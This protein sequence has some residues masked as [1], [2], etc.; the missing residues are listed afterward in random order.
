MIA[1]SE[2]KAWILP[3]IFV[4]SGVVGSLFVL[5]LVLP[6]GVASGVP[7][8]FAV[9]LTKDMPGRR[10][11]VLVGVLCSGLTVAGYFL[12]PPGGKEWQVLV[13]RGLSILAIG[14]TSLFMI[15]WKEYAEEVR[16]RAEDI[17][18]VIDLIPHMIYVRDEN[19]KMTM[20]NRQTAE[21]LG[22]SREE[23]LGLHEIRLSMDPVEEEKRRQA[24]T[25]VREQQKPECDEHEVYTSRQGETRIFQT[26]RMP[27]RSLYIPGECVLTVS[28]DQ[29][30]QMLLKG[31]WRLAKQ[32][33]DGSSDQIAILD[34]NYRYRRVN[35]AYEMAHGTTM[36]GI[37]GSSVSDLL[38]NE[39]F[40]YVIK[41]RLDQCLERV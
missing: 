24:E 20:A 23:L 14:M 38:G 41:P 1:K 13:N 2:R 39:T 18:A 8:L 30:D 33:F 10:V 9:F 31:S 22:I 40:Q 28:I 19:G 32:M 34:L 35:P 15:S 5:D 29:T 26:T 25:R 7:Y 4:L 11:T 36:E 6:L 17:Q 37:V 12:S 27:F 21:S 16:K 3:P